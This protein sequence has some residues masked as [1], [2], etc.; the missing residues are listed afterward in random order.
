MSEQLSNAHP[1][2]LKKNGDLMLIDKASDTKTKIA[3]YDR[4]TGDLEYE[5]ASFG[6][7]H[8]RG[9]AFAIGTINNGKAVSGL[10]IRT[11]GVKGEK[12][13]DLSKAP[14]M[15]KKDPQLGDQTPELV[16]WYFAWAPIE[17]V[18]RY[19]VYMDPSGEMVRRRVRRKWVEFIDDRGDG[20]YQLAEQN[21]GKGQQIGK[22]KWEGGEVA[23]VRSMEVL[24]N[25][26]IARRATCMTYSPNEC[27]T[28]FDAADDSEDQAAIAQEAA[29]AVES[30]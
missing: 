24:E 22:G 6:K 26:I 29:E 16:K 21:G 4:K 15:P 12:R 27:V 10:V 2:V 7:A 1:I 19:Q 9:C 28:P 14:P 3:F 23:E 20:G 30:T 8:A 17:A 25:Q 18:R 5:S 13:D 11:I